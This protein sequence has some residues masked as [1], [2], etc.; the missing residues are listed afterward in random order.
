MGTQ[1]AGF[2]G[3]RE[4]PNMVCWE[5]NWESRH[6]QPLSHFSCFHFLKGFYLFFVLLFLR[7]GLIA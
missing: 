4:L 1:V 3:D 7:H 6:F 5:L 2:T